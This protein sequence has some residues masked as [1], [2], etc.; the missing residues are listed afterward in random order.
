MVEEAAQA[1][2]SMAESM[3]RSF[4]YLEFPNFANNSETLSL[5]QA[6]LDFHRQQ[7]SN[8]INETTI[9]RTDTSSYIDAAVQNV[10]ASCLRFSVD[11]Y[12]S[13]EAQTVSQRLVF[14]LWDALKQDP[15]LHHFAKLQMKG[16]F[17]RFLTTSNQDL[18]D[19]AKKNMEWYTE[20][21]QLGNRVREPCVNLYFPPSDAFEKHHDGLSMTFLMLLTDVKDYQ[22]GGTKLYGPDPE[23]QEHIKVRPPAGTLLLWATDMMHE[24]LP[25][26]KGMR[27]VFVG[28][29]QMI[30]E[31]EMG[32]YPVVTEKI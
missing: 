13:N 29:F 20:Q 14:R 30:P 7:Q 15:Q 11:T 12:L 3:S 18:W 1:T 23:R 17:D 32:E 19:P 10:N 4:S 28:S 2:D 31:G 8:S 5:V 16:E 9:G 27:S 25:I 21:D 24:A 6:A 22:G 26:T